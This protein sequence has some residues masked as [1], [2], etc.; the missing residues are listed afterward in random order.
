MRKF[1]FYLAGIC[2][3][4]Y[5]NLPYHRWLWPVA[6]KLNALADYLYLSEKWKDHWREKLEHEK[7]VDWEKLP[8]WQTLIKTMSDP[9]LGHYALNVGAEDGEK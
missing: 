5:W 1:K 7:N 3:H 4:L 2:R 8:G 6:R 9:R